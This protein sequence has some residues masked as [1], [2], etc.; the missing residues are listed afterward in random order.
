MS[1][2]ST[3]LENFN[4]VENIVNQIPFP[5]SPKKIFT[6]LGIS[7]STLM[8]RY[9]AR[10]VENGSSLILAQH[11]GNYFQHKLHFN[12]IHEVKI[13]DKYLSWGNIK[14]KNVIPI[15]VIKNLSNT[16]KK[17][18]KIIIEIRMRR[19]YNLEIKIDSGFLES[20]KYLNDLCT[21]FSDPKKSALLP[22]GGTIAGH[23]GFALS[24]LV[25]I[26]AGALSGSECS[27]GTENKM[28]RNGVFILSV[29]P[30]KFVSLEDFQESVVRFLENL[31]TTTRIPGLEEILIPGERAFRER[32]KRIKNGI[33]IDKTTW[34]DIKKILIQV[35]LWNKYPLF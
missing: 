1:L 21:F 33:P 20:K 10:N 35:D 8:D 27:T 29:D 17:S 32:Q 14:K 4:I 9:I 2:P 3:Y 23:K 28:L 7:R 18:N 6:C 31:K 22:L 19:G 11:G 5:K 16:S 12:S 30:E 13:S 34:S 26:L 25:D 24:L 15:G